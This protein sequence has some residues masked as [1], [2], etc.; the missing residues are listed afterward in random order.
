MFKAEVRLL[1]ALP[2]F[3]RPYS[4]L[5]N[6][7]LNIGDI[8]A[9]P[10]GNSD[11]HQYGVVTSVEAG[12]FEKG[13][14]KILFLL[15]DLYSLNSV[16]LGCAEFISEQFFCTFGDALRLMLP[17]GLDI[18]TAE[19][20][21]KG[22]NFSELDDVDIKK[23]IEK[24]G[25]FYLSSSVTKKSVQAYLK[26]DVLRLHTEAVCHVN[27]KKERFVKL[28]P[29][30][31][32]EEKLKGLKNKELYK[33]VID[34]LS[35]ST[36]ISVKSLDEIYS[37]GASGLNT[38]VKR[39][40][41]EIIQKNVE[42][43]PYN[44]P[45]IKRPVKIKLSE[46]QEI[47]YTTLE[48]LLLSKEPSAALLYGVTGSGKTSVV[49][50]LIDKAVSE[51]RGVIMLVPEIA[52]T[53]QSAEVLFSRYS[54][55]V[56]IIHSG[57]SKGERYDS[58]QAIKSGKKNIVLGTRSAIFAPVKNLGLIVIDEEQDDSFK[59]DMTP[60]YRTKDVARFI[61]A[62]SSALMLLSSATPDVESFYNAKEGKYT[63]V[64]LSERY[65][66]ATLPDIVI[67]D[68]MTDRVASP[69]RL[70]GEELGDALRETLEKGEQAVLFVNRRGL[71]K[72]LT[73]RDCRTAV[74]CPNCSVPM[75]LHQKDGGYRLVC[76]YCGYNE[77]PPT[78]CPT[79][80]SR[81]MQYRGYGTQ[82][83][84]E[85]LKKLFPD[86]RV[87]RLDADSTRKKLSHE[88]IINDFSS[89]RADILIGTQMVAKGHN[90]EDVTLVGVIMADL[91][92]FSSDYRANEHTF[93]LMTQVV[94][95]AG[96]GKKKGRAILQTMN[97]FN[98][99]IELCT[100][101]NYEKFF[102]GEIALRRALIY[103]PFCS[104]AAFYLASD[105]EKE[106][107]NA[108]EKM[109]KAISEKLSGEFS[110]VKI[111]A[112]GPFEAIPYKLKNTYRRKLV[113]KFKNNK[114]TRELFRSILS[115]FNKKDKVRCFVDISP[116]V[117]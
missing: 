54:D 20:L 40:L 9:L 87:L 19:Y 82:K 17:T 95:R 99:I 13:L 35:G 73:C 81:H 101:Q 23:T 114:R 51:G 93:S 5:S 29:D 96:R 33:R 80:N 44:I 94:G 88:D 53:S 30:S 86:A 2:E 41:V 47:A 61:C 48:K 67:S 111:I 15:P 56:A 84:E 97:P 104:V 71:R 69:E 1:S 27:E 52:L 60:R 8:A 26:K 68:L 74:T 91:S 42:R 76:H 14:K 4:Y 55:K 103:P 92:L 63:L 37:V 117:L 75:T 22:D 57:M 45:K 43:T 36:E 113:V 116:T 49:L 100:T 72:L 112:Y 16:Q 25:R 28:V 79:C 32:S 31:F 11:R 98:E 34:H 3:D 109:E 77:E 105:S 115:E 106:L 62:K 12:E 102:N 108:S 46:K 90:F 6:I 24:D 66:K 83:L 65:G 110:D 89:H 70:I 10:F 39:G 21:V 38:L 50:S 18:V 107:D 7:P 64:T 58:W 59:S 78:V 85:E